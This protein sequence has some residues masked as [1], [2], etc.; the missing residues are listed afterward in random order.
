MEVA[1]STNTP[2]KL[3]G[4]QV[5]KYLTLGMRLWEEAGL[6][7]TP[8]RMSTMVKQA[9]RRYGLGAV[10]WIL[11]EYLNAAELQSWE[12]YLRAMQG[13]SFVAVKRA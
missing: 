1:F 10:E 5:D 2:S 7:M 6:H 13:R 9:A 8:G 4:K 12:S 11:R 3:D